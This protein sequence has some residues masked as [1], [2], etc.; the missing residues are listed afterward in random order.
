MEISKKLCL[1]LEII[2]GV[3]FRI[4][5]DLKNFKGLTAKHMKAYYNVK[6]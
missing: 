2:I 3:R 6:K 1:R 4:V 5:V